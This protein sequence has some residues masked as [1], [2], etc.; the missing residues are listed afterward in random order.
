M[1][2]PYRLG[3][4]GRTFPF[5]VIKM[6]SRSGWEFFNKTFFSPFLWKCLFIKT[7]FFCKKNPFQ[8]YL[9]LVKLS[10]IGPGGISGKTEK[11]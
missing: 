2:S 1:V 11:A 9:S 5:A 3:N 10:N 4:F 8:L 6:L 7:T